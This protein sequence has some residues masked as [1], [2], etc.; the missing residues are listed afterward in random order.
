MYL[1]DKRASD[2]A[3]M[4]KDAASQKPDQVRPKRYLAESLLDT[5]DFAA[6]A[7]EF[8]QALAIDPKSASAQLGLGQSLERQ[9]KLDDA[10]PH[11]QTAATLDPKLQSYLLELAA[12]YSKA[13]R[14]DQAV[15]LLKQFPDDVGA[16]EEL[17]RLYLSSNQAAL[18]VPEFETAAKLSA[19]PANR[20]ALASAYL[21]NNQADLAEPILTQ[22]LA[23][24]PQDYDIRMAVGRIRRDRHDYAAAANQFYAAAQI[25][26]ES[27]EAWKE[28]ATSSVLG[29]QYQ[30]ALAALDKV[31]TLR[32]ETAGDFYL[33][34]IVLDKFHQVKPALQI[35][36]RFL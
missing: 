16:H 21:R 33:R 32:A 35:I 25:K 9:G 22:A 30:Q 24:S 18:A 29:E 7:D 27:V 36:R 20:L 3:P 23:A 4:L 28:M 17:G 5:G 11:D 14:T 10:L 15:A 1:R 34:A 31:H 13:N 8:G 2:A 19:T 12:A 6:A 26:P